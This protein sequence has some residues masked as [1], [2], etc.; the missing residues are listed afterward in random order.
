MGTLL[1]YGTWAAAKEP[2]HP[3]PRTKDAVATT[4]H[5]TNA[6]SKKT[7]SSKKIATAEQ[8]VALIKQRKDVKEFLALFPEGKGPKTGGTPVVEAEKQ[9]GKWLVHVYEALPDHTATHN[10]YT[11]DPASGSVTPMF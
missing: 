2:Q 8:A 3:A 9:D 4:T 11:V 10:W 1:F 5:S 6:E 7:G